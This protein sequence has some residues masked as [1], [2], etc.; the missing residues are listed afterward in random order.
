LIVRGPLGSGKTTVS[1][2]LADE[3]GA[4]VLS[5]DEILELD[6]WDGGSES[7][8]LRANAGAAERAGLLLRRGTPVIFD[9]NFYWESAIDDLERRLPYP[10]AV[11]SLE[12]PLATCVERDSGRSPS[13][14]AEAT[15]EVFEKVERVRRGIPIDGSGELRATVRAVR[16]CLP[17]ALRT[18]APA[19]PRE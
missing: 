11:F 15:A 10:R 16:A 14:G 1:H 2:V 18:R 9:G 3:L 8:F 13:Y 7:L 5:I 4:E 6:S 17:D 12:V 19:K